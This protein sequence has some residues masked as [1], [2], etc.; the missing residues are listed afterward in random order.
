MTPS[1]HHL[2]WIAPAIW[3]DI[4]DG[5]VTGLPEDAARQVRGWAR[6]G[7]PV[8]L[9]RRG[10]DEP[11]DGLPV[12]LPLPP[13]LGKQRL[14]LRVPAGAVQASAPPRLLSGVATAA[15]AA[16]QDTIGAL[17]ALGAACETAPRCFG[18]LLWQSL[19]GLDYLVPGSDLDLLWAPPAQ[20]LAGLLDGLA[21]L[22]AAAPVRLDGEIVG[23]DGMAANWRELA[24]GTDQVLL[25]QGDAVVL[26]RFEARPDRSRAA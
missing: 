18:S 2:L 8:M 3:D 24:Q 22:D 20:H 4:C 15:P 19:T 9:R 1:R 7:R 11:R 13:P 16:W 26:G 25:K 23:M 14:A 17:L 21:R 5:A 10:A 6:L 12:G